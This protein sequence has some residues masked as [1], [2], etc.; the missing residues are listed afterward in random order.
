MLRTPQ[1]DGHCGDATQVCGDCYRATP[2]GVLLSGTPSSFHACSSSELQRSKHTVQQ[3]MHVAFPHPSTVLWLPVGFI[4]A[5]HD[6]PPCCALLRNV[7]HMHEV[8]E[9]LN[10]QPPQPLVPTMGKSCVRGQAV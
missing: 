8:C 6:A 4:C 10:I 5:W 3:N 2:A 7:K 1:L 9:S